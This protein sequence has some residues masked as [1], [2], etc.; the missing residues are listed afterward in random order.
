MSL[1]S[2]LAELVAKLPAAA[3]ALVVE[4][5]RGAVA[6]EDPVRYLERRLAAETSHTA[7]QRGVREALRRTAKKP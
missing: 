4:L 7:V 6:S 2:T 5:V 3:V 1:A